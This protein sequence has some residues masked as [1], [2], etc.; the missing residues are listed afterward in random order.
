MTAPRNVCPQC[1]IIGY[2][3]GRDQVPCHNIEGAT[4]NA[5]FCPYRD[6]MGDLGKALASQDTRDRTRRDV[7]YIDGI[8][9]SYTTAELLGMIG[10]VVGLVLTF[11][12]FGIVWIITP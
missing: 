9:L 1:G 3:L 7:D 2:R 6:D 10:F 12:G 11:V 4:C 5:A 8:D